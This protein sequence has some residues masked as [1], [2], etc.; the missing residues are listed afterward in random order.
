MVWVLGK[1]IPAMAWLEPF[2][3]AILA[4][5]HEGTSA[6]LMDMLSFRDVSQPARREGQP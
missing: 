4:A 3:L 1:G 6:R 2:A 5:F